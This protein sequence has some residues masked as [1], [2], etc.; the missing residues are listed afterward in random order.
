MRHFCWYMADFKLSGCI[1][2]YCIELLTV[3]ISMDGWHIFNQIWFLRKSHHSTNR[4]YVFSRDLLAVQC[5]SLEISDT[6]IA[7][8][9]AL[10]FNI[11]SMLRYW[12][13]KLEI[14]CALWMCRSSKLWFS[15]ARIWKNSRTDFLH[16]VNMEH[17]FT[18]HDRF[19]LDNIEKEHL[20]GGHIRASTLNKLYC[21][22][23]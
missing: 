23:F 17:Y 4:L 16:V 3:M 7:I 15:C 13:T 5:A 18:N 9:C 21:S 6:N 1:G 22:D 12:S 11:Y 2:N 10:N 20:T 19:T 8:K 14:L